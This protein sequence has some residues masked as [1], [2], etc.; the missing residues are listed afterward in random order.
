MK[1]RIGFLVSFFFLASQIVGQ[2]IPANR[3]IPNESLSR[4]LKDDLKKLYKN[5]S[6][7]EL[8][9]YFREKFAERYF[10]DWKDVD[11]RLSNYEN[12]YP[13]VQKS[14]K[15][16]AEDHISKFNANT[17]WK[18][19]F[20]Y[21]NGNPV[22]AYALRHLARQHK[23]VD[24]ALMYF[25]EDKNPKYIKYFRDQQSSLNNALITN[26]F[27]SIEDGNGVYEAFRSGYR[28]LNWLQIHNLFLGEAEYSDEDQLRTIS[29]LLQHGAHL[30]KTNATFS[31]GNHQTRGMSALAMLSILFQ[32]FKDSD[33]WF[34]RSI[35]LLEMHLNQEINP[36]GFQFERS[37]H[38]HMSD[39]DNYYFVYQLAKNSGVKLNPLWDKKMESLF[40]T[41]VKIAFPDKSAPVFSD[42]TD[43]PW[44]EK[45][46]ISGA[47]TLGYLLFEKPEMGYFANNKVDPKMFW[48]LSNKQLELLTDV[49]KQKPTLG[50]LAF[51]DTG[52]YIM[53]DGW[54]KN[55]R[56]LVVSAGLDPDKP[57]HQHGDM[58][59]IQAMAN[60]HVILPNYQVRYSLEDLELFK[61]S[62]VK[63]VA[64]IDDELQ[65][66]NY[67][68]NQGGSGF[69]KFAT[70]PQPKT[71]VWETYNNIDIYIG[72]HDGFS[73]NGV[74]YNRQIINNKDGGFWIIKDNFLA[75]ASHDYKQV[76]QG[77]Y[78]F[79]NGP[80]LLRATFDDGAG[81]DILQLH[82]IDTI[83]KGGS[84]G[85]HWNVM[86]TKN[87][88]QYSFITVVYP[89]LKF[90]QRIDENL[91][92]TVVNNY[93]VDDFKSIKV[94]PKAKLL[95]KNRSI[96]AFNM[97]EIRFQNT[98]LT[99]DK[100]VDVLLK[101]ENGNLSILS[102]D[103]KEVKLLTQ[104][105]QILNKIIKPGEMYKF[106]I[107]N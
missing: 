24:I 35:E 70:L 76:W 92:E 86:T 10:Y 67:K 71:L 58:L 34:N 96:Y 30:Y 59:G 90:D 74:S 20:N 19:P 38:Y 22:N 94:N 91:Q 15:E 105:S 93:I 65:G 77:H 50:S 46:D 44:S 89:F 5:K 95:S 60:G 2:S 40:S 99:F 78:T 8:A 103:S 87:Q 47:L 16:R 72:S 102:L 39:I 106:Q 83:T 36:D 23:M 27:E 82:A 51:K 48:Y 98:H 69:G 104:N 29:T 80:Q 53:R 64:L 100:T 33:A 28:I 45:N 57:D 88:S 41:L 75:D 32:D 6:N 107:I 63:N 55:D 79:E 73:T 97:S 37:V 52:Y 4:Y 101:F 66:K 42:D 26:K 14:H 61:N 56:M 7:A 85:K 49:K 54:D 21:I 11:Q 12:L 13:D 81:V 3:V 31:P 18:L 62:M 1:L 17:T 68:S 84:R 9:S 43:T 25:Y